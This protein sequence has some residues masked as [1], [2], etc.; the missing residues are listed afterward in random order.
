MG[1]L[2]KRLK[3][4]V[5]KIS[6]SAVDYIKHRAEKV[7]EK[8]EKRIIGI[9]SAVLNKL[10]G[11]MLIIVGV[12]FLGLSLFY[13]LKDYIGLGNSFSYLVLGIIILIVGITFNSLKG[14]R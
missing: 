6:D 14:D 11:I 3:K 4:G 1:D 5:E 7:G 9:E 12:I 13:L 10:L 2:K 8:I